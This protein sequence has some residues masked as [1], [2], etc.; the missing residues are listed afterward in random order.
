MMVAMNT[1]HEDEEP[2]RP[3]HLSRIETEPSTWLFRPD[4]SAGVGGGHYLRTPKHEL[5]REPP[6]SIGGRLGE[7]R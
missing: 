5:P 4:E 2:F 1:D 7:G 3:E 6:P